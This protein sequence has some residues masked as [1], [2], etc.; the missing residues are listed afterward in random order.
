MI[1][2][3]ITIMLGLLVWLKVPDWITHGPTNVKQWVQLGCNILGI[4]I[5]LSG[6][7]SLFRQLF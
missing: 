1:S 2:S 6:S 7:L 5:T 3:I 4:L